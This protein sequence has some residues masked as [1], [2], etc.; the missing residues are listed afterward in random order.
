MGKLFFTEKIMRASVTGA[1]LNSELFG[2]LPFEKGVRTI[3]TK[4]FCLTFTPV[5]M[6]RACFSANL[7]F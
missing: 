6:G 1:L 7:A 5:P 3:W 4:V 2:F